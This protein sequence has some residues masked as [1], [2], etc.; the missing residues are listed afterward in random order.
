MQRNRSFETHSGCGAAVA[1]AAVVAGVDPLLAFVVGLVAGVFVELIQWAFPRF[2]GPSVKDV[3]YTGIG[4]FIGAL[5]A[6][7]F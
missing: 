7:L 2:G 1:L 4:A 3:I 5:W 6:S